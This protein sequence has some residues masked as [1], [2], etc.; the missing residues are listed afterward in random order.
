MG[1]S[2]ALLFLG[3]EN[4]GK[5]FGLSVLQLHGKEKKIVLMSCH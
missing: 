2:G 4:M 1:K 3:Y 5:F